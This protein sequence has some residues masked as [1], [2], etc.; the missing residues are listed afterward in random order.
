VGGGDIDGVVAI[1]LQGWSDVP[2]GTAMVAEGSSLL[3]PF[4]D[5]G[6]GAK[7]SQWC[8]VKIKVPEEL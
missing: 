5:D 3:G 1:V 4:I 6:S 7:G 2:A 8:F